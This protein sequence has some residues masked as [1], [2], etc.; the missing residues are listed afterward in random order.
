MSTQ[1]ASSGGS[2]L[3]QLHQECKGLPRSERV[4]I[5][6]DFEPTDYQADLLD[7]LEQ[8]DKGRA[9]PQKGRQ[10]GATLTAGVVG[11]DHA[12]WAPMLVGE[13]TDVLFAAPGQETADE[14]F[15]EAKQRF[16]KGPLTLE[17]YGVVKKNEQTWKFSSGTRML[18]RT[19]GNVGQED[20]P[21]NR[22]KNPTCVIVDEAAYEKD[23]VYEEEIEQFFITHPVFEYVLFST[24]A[25]KSGYFYA[26]VEHDDDWFSPHWPTRISPYAQEDYIE[27]QREKLD[28]ETFAQE[29]EG[30]FAEDGG[31]AIPHDTLIPNIKP[32][33]RFDNSHGRFLGVDPARGGKDEMVVFDLD[34]T[35]VCW[36]VWAFET[37]DGP[38]FVELLEILHQQKADLEY[39]DA[40][41]APEVG[42][43]RTPASGYQTILIEENGVG[44]FAADFAEAGLGDVVK[45]VNST[46][47]TK[48]NIYQRLIKDL[49]AESLALPNHDK[50]ERQVTKLEKSFTPT[51]KAKYSAPAG[52]HDDWPDGMAFANWARHGGGDPLDD[53][54]DKLDSLPWRS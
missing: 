53:G 29:Y 43:G 42:T 16:K 17:Q 26:K 14:M 5:I 19:L 23:V 31:S 30:K 34:A 36:S 28:S 50:L 11:A 35:G 49:E 25:G 6:F 37:M 4:E 10:V 18:S 15:E 52:K 27:E 1:T 7:H 48:Q 21:G 8:A 12:L 20:Q 45:V 3:E 47:E 40:I 44:G 33:R 2:P 38:R 9:A 32:D 22:G 39:W 24:P 13:P 54:N 41:P 51:G 46:N